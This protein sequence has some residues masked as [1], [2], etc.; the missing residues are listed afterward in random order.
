M[1]T[2]I[3]QE[4]KNPITKVV[5]FYPAPARCVP[6]SLQDIV[7]RISQ[8]CTVDEPDVKAVLSALQAQI[9]LALRNGHSVR[10]G[11]LG[12]FRLTMSGYGCDLKEE[13]GVA[14]IKRLRVCY[15]MSS[16]LRAA[17]KKGQP[18]IE[19]IMPGVKSYAAAKARALA[20]MARK[21]AQEAQAAAEAAAAGR[22]AIAGRV[23]MYGGRDII[24]A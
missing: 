16:R 7:E 24:R 17:F 21:D 4:R 23:P 15:T 12:S 11:D 13:V 9:I 3:A 18:G 14:A 22:E 6:M 19:F 8:T 1:I 2:F 20:Q 5:K 10:L